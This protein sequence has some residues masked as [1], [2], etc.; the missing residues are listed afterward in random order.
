MITEKFGRY[1]VI[2]TLGAGSMGAVYK[3]EDPDNGNLVAV[4]LI[5]SQVLYDQPRR[6]R[7]LQDMLAVSMVHDPRICRILEIGDD[8]DDFYI[9]TALLEGQTVESILRRRTFT[10]REAFGIGCESARTL[11]VLHDRGIVH[12]GIKPS[13][14]WIDDQSRVVLTDCAISRFT[15]LGHRFH[16]PAALPRCEFAD[17]LIPLAA[18][19]YMSPEQV[20]GETVDCRSDVFSLGVVLYEMISGRHPFEA[21][22]SLSKTSAI[23]EAEPAQLASRNE[24]VSPELD[25]VVRK[26]LA[27]NQDRRQQSAAQLAF[28]LDS[29]AEHQLS[30]S[31]PIPSEP[32]RAWY[33][34]LPLLWTAIGALAA[35]TVTA[36]FLAMFHA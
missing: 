21:R 36:V 13:N 8:D 27:K 12:R 28:E 22:N 16:V 11:Q 6:E 23:L 17:T 14:I 7:F 20:R 34:R 30:L 4:K 3:A 5:R 15:E 32:K 35:I 29:V 18:L 9:V 31:Q 1:A 10:L 24:L 33:R 19:S 25:Q 26:A 2:E